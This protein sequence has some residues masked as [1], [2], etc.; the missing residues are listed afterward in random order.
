ME[1]A[2]AA[3][4][5]RPP[6]SLCTIVARTHMYTY[7]ANVWDLPLVQEPFSVAP[8]QTL[9]DRFATCTPLGAYQVWIHFLGM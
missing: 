4:S 2:H 9:I 6:I 5:R 8:C 7:A 3:V 1:I